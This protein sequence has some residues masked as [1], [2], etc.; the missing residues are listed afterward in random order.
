[1]EVEVDAAALL[2]SRMTLAGNRFNFQT[3]SDLIYVLS[4]N[5]TPLSAG[6]KR[7]YGV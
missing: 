1:M 6:I 3:L 5:G 4:H 7:G 2:G